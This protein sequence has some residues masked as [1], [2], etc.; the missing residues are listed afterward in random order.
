MHLTKRHYAGKLGSGGNRAR[1]VS[2]AEVTLLLAH[3]LG[4]NSNPT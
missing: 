2:L 3:V 4:C 1:A